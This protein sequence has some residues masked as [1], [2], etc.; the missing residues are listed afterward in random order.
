MLFLKPLSTVKALAL[1]FTNHKMKNF[2][3]S[4]QIL[5]AYFNFL[6]NFSSF[7]PWRCL[8]RLSWITTQYVMKTEHTVFCISFSIQFFA[9]FFLCIFIHFLAKYFD[10]CKFCR[11]IFHLLLLPVKI[12]VITPSNCAPVA[13]FVKWNAS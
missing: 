3:K 13:L 12:G 11:F 2:T 7:Y 1:S 4:Q 8:Y 10:L 6:L 9:F 5:K